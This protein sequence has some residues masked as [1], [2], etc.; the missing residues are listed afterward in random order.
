M[1]GFPAINV[2]SVQFNTSGDTVAAGC[3]NGTVQIIDVATAEV[4]RPLSG[5]SFG[6]YSVCW[7]NGGT[8]LSSGSSDKTVKVWDPTTGECL[9]TLN[10]DGEVLSVAYSPDGTKLTACLDYPSV[11][12]FD[13]QTNEQICSLSVDG[14][15]SGAS[16]GP[17]VATNSPLRAIISMTTASAC[18]SSARRG[19]LATSYASRP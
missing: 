14:E 12:V 4:K 16:I 18:R 5:H 10:V 6:V 9:W 13:T 1:G 11:V 17:H 2:N 19:R 8:K 15:K 3:M 7:N